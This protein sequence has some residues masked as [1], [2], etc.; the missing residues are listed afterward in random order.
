MNIAILISGSEVKNHAPPLSGA[1]IG[2]MKQRTSAA[3]GL[4]ITA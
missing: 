4:I 1:V 2:A 3:T